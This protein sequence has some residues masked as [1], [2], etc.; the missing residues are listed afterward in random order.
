MRIIAGTSR[1]TRLQEPAEVTR[2]TSD[3]VREAIFNVLR[4]VVP[5][6][7]V[8]DLYAGTGALGLEALSRG[9]ES[10]TFVD[11]HPQAIRCLRKNVAKCQF[12]HARIVEGDSVPF[13]EKN[14]HSSYDLIFA[15][16]PYFRDGESD[17]IGAL[18][19]LDL[20]LSPG[21]ILVLEV[22]AERVTPARD[23]LTFLKRK[24]Y[25]K[26]S[27]LYFERTAQEPPATSP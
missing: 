13:L 16:P 19:S 3:R 15:D 11:H 17:H 20:P 22:E 12:A 8:L 18:L 26:T 27:V 2:P 14:R 1:G 10:C 25:G 24:D 7:K 9:A 21:G 23:G 6:A 4:H 5:G